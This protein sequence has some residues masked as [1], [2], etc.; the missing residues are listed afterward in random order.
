MKAYLAL[1]C[2]ITKETLSKGD[3]GFHTNLKEDLGFHTNLKEE[4]NNCG[5]DKAIVYEVTF[6][7]I[8]KYEKHTQTKFI[9]IKE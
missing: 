3:L 5:E 9:K 2:E 1:D 4:L 7:R 6:K 8:G